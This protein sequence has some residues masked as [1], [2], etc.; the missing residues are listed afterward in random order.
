MGKEGNSMNIGVKIR[1]SKIIHPKLNRTLIVAMDHGLMMGTIPGLVDFR[2]TFRQVRAGGASAVILTPGLI[3]A[4]QDLL[5]GRDSPSLVFRLDWTNLL[6]KTLPPKNGYETHIATPEEAIS[7]GA[8]AAI[9]YLFVGYNRD[10][11][12]VRNIEN[13]ARAVMQCHRL[14]LPL[15]IEPMARGGRVQQD[16]Y[17]PEYVRLHVRMAAELGA[18]LIKTDYTGDPDTFHQAIKGCPTPVVIAG[19][20]KLKTEEDA[21]RMASE[22]LEAGAIGVVYGRNVIQAKNPQKMTRALRALILEGTTLEE[23]IKILRD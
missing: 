17:N 7:Y 22:A 10:E 2:E 23:A 11:A 8:D 1:L 9:T 12:E 5:S 16:K 13:V 20:P 18:D 15:I 19:G 3:R 4:C 14:G 21:L 6:R